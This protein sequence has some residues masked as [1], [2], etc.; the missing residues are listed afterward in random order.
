MR[1]DPEKDISITNLVAAIFFWLLT[2]GWIALIFFLS[3][4]SGDLSSDRSNAILKTIELLFGEGV[5]T[6]YILRKIAHVLEFSV[7]TVLTFIAIRF[8]NKVSE[9]RS[10]AESPVKFIKSDNE[11]YIAISL[12]LSLLT[13]VV[14]EYHQLFVEG[15]DGSIKDVLIDSI[16]IFS[17]LL[18]IRVGFSIYLRYLGAKEVRYE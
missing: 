12:W 17:V 7:L 9:I 4:E 6:D 10:Y 16:G 5:I 11:M 14:D 1:N 2:A 13:A 3:N 15:R 8:T 18:I